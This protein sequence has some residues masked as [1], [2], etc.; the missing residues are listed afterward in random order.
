MAVLLRAAQLRGQ[1]S[2][3]DVGVELSHRT[4]HHH[5]RQQG[6]P[7]HHECRTFP[8]DTEQEASG[9]HLHLELILV[10]LEQEV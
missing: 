8:K 2:G 6:R 10:E 5:L 9:A 1:L 7:R 3:V 4:Q